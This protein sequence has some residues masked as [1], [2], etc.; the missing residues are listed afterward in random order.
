M[1]NDFLTGE[2][3][4]HV[5]EG[6]PDYTAMRSHDGADYYLIK[7]FVDAVRFNDPSRIYSGVNETLE[8]HIM[9]FAAE[10]SRKGGVVVDIAT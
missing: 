10:R 9:T 6:P 8:S 3:I 4:T 1:Q 7:Q 2:R 5:A